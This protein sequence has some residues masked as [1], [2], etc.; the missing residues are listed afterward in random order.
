MAITVFS[1][2]NNNYIITILSQ[3]SF[4]QTIDSIWGIVKTVH[5]GYAKNGQRN[6][7]IKPRC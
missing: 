7:Y 1:K 2:F 6:Y 4:T 5:K 3:Y